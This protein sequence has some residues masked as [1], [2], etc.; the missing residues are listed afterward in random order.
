MFGLQCAFVLMTQKEEFSE[1]TKM[2]FFVFS[3][4]VFKNSFHK[5]TGPW[6]SLKIG[7][8]LFI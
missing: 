4:T 5:Q 8:V 6:C 2:V 1:N 3:K 7:L